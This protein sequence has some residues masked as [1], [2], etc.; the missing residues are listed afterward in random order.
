VILGTFKSK[1][2]GSGTV[3]IIAP[4]PDSDCIELPLIFVAI[5]FAYMLEPHGRLNGA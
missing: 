4:F 1:I 2:G 3:K 5:I